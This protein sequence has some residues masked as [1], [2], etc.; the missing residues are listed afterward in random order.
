MGVDDHGH[1]TAPGQEIDLVRHCEVIEETETGHHIEACHVE[2]AYVR[3]DPGNAR[4]GHIAVGARVD[5]GDLPAC[6]GGRHRELAVA[7]SQIDKTS[8]REELE[9]TGE[10][11]DSVTAANCQAVSPSPVIRQTGESF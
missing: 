2:L 8:G 6:L 1:A 5:S 9:Q 3:L 4:S 11:L 7:G 10:D